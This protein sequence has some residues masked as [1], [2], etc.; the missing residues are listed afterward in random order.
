MLLKEL[1]YDSDGNFVIDNEGQ[2][3]KDIY[4]D[5]Y[6][7]VDNMLILPSSTMILDNNPVSIARY[8]EE[9]PDVL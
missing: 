1:G 5:E 6:V 4:I 7:R 9:H 3:V 8:M 2:K